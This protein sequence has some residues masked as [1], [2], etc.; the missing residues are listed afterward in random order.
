MPLFVK[1][2]TSLRNLHSIRR[3]EADLDQE[4]HSHLEMLT[5]DKIRAGMSPDEALRSARIELGGIEQLKEQVREERIGSFGFSPSFLTAVS[6]FASF[7]KIPA[8]PPSPF[9]LWLSA[10]APTPP[11]SLLSIPGTCVCQRRESRREGR[12]D[13]VN[14]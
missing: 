8:L 11:C 9:L 6:V 1:A 4:I 3:V 13:R 12:A 10:L 2:R 5:G 14:S 7:A